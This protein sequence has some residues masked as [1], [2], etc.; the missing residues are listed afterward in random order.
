MREREVMF[1]N[2]GAGSLCKDTEMKTGMVLKCS[3]LTFSYKEQSPV[4]LAL[5]SLILEEKGLWQEIH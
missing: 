4:Q 5:A 3:L 1:K 2:G